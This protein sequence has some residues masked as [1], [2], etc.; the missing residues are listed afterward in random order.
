MSVRTCKRSM[1]YSEFLEWI[2]FLSRGPEAPGPN[3]VS[4]DDFMRIATGG[5]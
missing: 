2:V 5:K 3:I 1:S 4:N